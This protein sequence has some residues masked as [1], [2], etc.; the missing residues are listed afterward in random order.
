MSAI[1]L[2]LE[3][4]NDVR[5][6]LASGLMGLVAAGLL[7]WGVRGLLI[8]QQKAAHC[9]AAVA[10]AAG[11]GYLLISRI[12]PSLQSPVSLIVAW[13]IFAAMATAA[14]YLRLIGAIE[15]ARLVL[16]GSMRFAA[17]G[18]IILLLFRPT[19]LTGPGAEAKP[20]IAVLIDS[21]GSMQTV[22]RPGE[23][24]RYARAVAAVLQHRR[25]A[26][27]YTLRIYRFSKSLEAVC[28]PQTL[29]NLPAD[30][31]ATS[32]SL[33]LTELARQAPETAA[34]IVLSDGDHNS[35]P[36]PLQAAEKLP[37]PVYAVVAGSQ[38]PRGT[39]RVA[40]TAVDAPLL[41]AADSRCNVRVRLT[42]TALKGSTLVVR[43]QKSD[44]EL[45]S[46]RIEVTSDI[47]EAAADLSFVP[48]QPGREELAVSVTAF[49][50]QSRE[51]ADSAPVRLLVFRSRA[52]ILYLEGRVRPEYRVLRRVIGSEPTL[53]LAAAVRIAPDVWQLTGTVNGK[54]VTSFPADPAEFQNFVKQF[55]VIILGD[56]SS[57]E[58]GAERMQA[59]EKWTRD[60]GGLLMIGGQHN[61]AAGQYANTPIERLLP[62]TLGLPEPDGQLL[63]D[64]TPFLPRL[65]PEGKAHPATAGLEKYLS[66]I[67]R[68]RLPRLQGCAIV[69]APKPAAEVLME[70][71]EVRRNGKP[72][73]VLAVQNY[74][75]G[76]SAAF[77]A[78]TTYLWYQARPLLQR[79][80]PC[81]V[82]WRQL[83]RWL[84]GQ[85]PSELAQPAIL[86]RADAPHHKTGQAINLS[87]VVLTGDIAAPTQQKPS[88]NLLVK[89]PSGSQIPVSPSLIPGERLQF[90]GKFTPSEPGTYTITAEATRDSRRLA[91]DRLQLQVAGSTPEAAGEPANPELL[92]RL[93]EA[94]GGEL[95]DLEAFRN[96]LNLLNERTSATAARSRP[97]VWLQ[98]AAHPV[99]M[100]LLAVC[101]LT[102]EWLLRQRWHLT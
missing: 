89:T 96:L 25:A 11:L 99:A 71:P 84:A 59:I 70:H 40:I 21:S 7:V 3:F 8:R 33:A 22:D 42:A 95:F 77:T 80:S 56:L 91:T 72:L 39:A 100:F 34:A 16:L 26:R 74:G 17:I 86:V 13:T 94:S 4:A 9:C 60:G 66:G 82:F 30:G 98:P 88:V 24:N 78:D 31:P 28:D 68:H 54:P 57:P 20:T 10:G 48:R 14:G 18:L 27:S 65:T 29:P 32:I 45:D 52:R 2:T 49:S 101:V 75:K 51:A 62:V 19:L 55:D 43:L 36:D 97:M 102:C 5:P 41:A 58:L 37:F 81:E 73:I 85:K 50:G 76:R 15:P 53:E 6:D 23:P 46:A 35:G 61:F 87:G 83:L 44:T 1:G 79:R 90:S 69:G 64:R 92:K 12:V 93:A 63:Q 38:Q 67:G 47:F